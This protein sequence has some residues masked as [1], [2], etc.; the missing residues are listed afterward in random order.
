MPRTSSICSSR[1]A[2]TTGPRTSSS[3]WPRRRKRPE[4]SA[5]EFSVAL[6]ITPTQVIEFDAESFGLASNNGQMIE[7]F[8]AKAK[9]AQQFRELA[10][11]LTH[12]KELKEEKKP[13][14]LAPLLEKFKL[15]R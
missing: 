10:L 12:R 15:K 2:P 6:D 5:K 11:T 13:S 4:I 7:E 8:A 9:A 14:A 1:T 3:T